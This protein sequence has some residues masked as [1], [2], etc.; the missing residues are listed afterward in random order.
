MCGAL[1]FFFFFFRNSRIRLWIVYQ[2]IIHQADWIYIA[3]FKA[4]VLLT[5][6]HHACSHQV[7]CG[8]CVGMN[9]LLAQVG[10]LILALINPG[11][12]HH[13]LV[14]GDI[15]SC[16]HT[17][18]TTLNVI[19]S[20][21]CISFL[22]HQCTQLEVTCHRCLGRYVCIATYSRTVYTTMLFKLNKM[23]TGA[24]MYILQGCV[25]Y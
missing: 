3:M 2:S 12:A 16:I 19:R 11:Q 9:S 24:H 23:F 8:L 5:Y 10:P 15:T 13:I 20:S 7:F 14:L 18:L 17:F 6:L 1:I 22:G 21:F 25:L 4:R